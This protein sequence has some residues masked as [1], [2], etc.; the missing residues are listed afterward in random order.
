[1][2]EKD[3]RA[4]KCAYLP[5][6][7][8]RKADDVPAEGLLGSICFGSSG[9]TKNIP[10]R[11]TCISTPALDAEGRERAACELW[12]MDGAVSSGVRGELCFTHND[13]VL[14]GRIQIDEA[15]YPENEHIGKTP[16]Q[17]AAE[18]AYRDIFAL[19][20]E[21]RFPHVL[22]FW[23]HIVD[24]NVDSYGL[25]RYRQFNSGRQDGFLSAGREIAGAVVPAASAVGCDEGPLTVYF[26]ASRGDRPV[27]VENPRQV[28]AY[29]YPAAYGPRSP[30]FS[31]A[32][33]ADIGGTHVLFLSGTAS[34]AGHVS[35]HVGDVTAQV[36]ETMANIEAMIC[37]AN[38]VVPQAAFKLDDLCFKIYIR[39]AQD[40]PLV[41]RELERLAGKDARMLFLRAD[42]CRRDL[43]VE[44]EA[45]AGHPMAFDFGRDR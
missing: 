30:T 18:L 26:L 5:L 6:D 7:R 9:E 43:L 22:R 39:S 17:W 25:E 29:H 36:R 42:I 34:I 44:I 27:A 19:L 3:P 40:V 37:E 10:E 21:M 12:S 1:M 28:S 35:M 2:T 38:R 4:L 33:V 31:R 45:T 32:S 41:R 15:D 13:H 14:F 23:N 16:L 8:C 20:D 11:L 24:I